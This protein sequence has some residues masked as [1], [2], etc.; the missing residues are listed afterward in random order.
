MLSFAT[1]KH[2]S[3]ATYIF[4]RWSFSLG[5]SYDFFGCRLRAEDNKR[6]GGETVTRGR[7]R[8]LKTA[9]TPEFMAAGQSKVTC[10]SH[11]FKT[12]E[13]GGTGF[14]IEPPRRGIQQNG[15]AHASSMVHPTVADKEWN[16]GG[17]MKRQTN[18]ELKS[19]ISQTG[20]LSGDSYRRDSNRDYSTVS[21]FSPLYLFS[22]P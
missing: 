2:E 18:A 15:K 11:K 7:P 1:K 19:R 12:D 4:I 10:I 13:E 22:V 20:D 17:S 5:F 14:R 9:Q 16:R 21:L 8:D 6:R 3:I